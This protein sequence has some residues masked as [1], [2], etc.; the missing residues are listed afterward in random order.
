M[1]EVWS[2]GRGGRFSREEEDVK[3]FWEWF[4]K[5]RAKKITHGVMDMVETQNLASVL[6]KKLQGALSVNTDYLRQVPFGYIEGT[7][8][9]IRNIIR[10]TYG[11][12]RV[13]LLSVFFIHTLMLNA[14]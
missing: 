8:L 3:P 7:N 10:R 12:S 14:P 4:G 5:D 2:E 6:Y 13:A 11:Y 9:K 1:S